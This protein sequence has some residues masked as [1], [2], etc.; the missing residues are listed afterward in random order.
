[1]LSSGSRDQ[2]CGPRTVLFWSWVFAVFVYWSLVSLPHPL[3]LGQGQW[4]VSWPPA[5]SVLCWFA[6]CFSILQCCLTLN[7]AHWLRRWALWTATALFQA[8]AYH[9]TAIGPP[10]FPAFV[11][12]KFSWRS[13]PCPSPFSGAL[14]AP[15]PL[16][17][18]LVFS[19]LFI[20]QFFFCRV[21]GQFAR[22]AMLVYPRGGWGNTVWCLV[23]TCWSAGCL[24][25]GLEPVSGGVAAFCFLSVSFLWARGL[26]CWCFD[27]LCCFI[28]LKHGSSASARFLIHGAHAVCFCALV[29]ILDR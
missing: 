11:Y 2:L 6:D 3:S 8:V 10:A 16:C 17:C 7:V 4:S 12:W 21:G 23:L 24:P 20:V 9:P 26:G 14:T 29:A 19:S 28:S 25:A 27:S 15:R 22:G 5:V 13:S 18:V 1:M